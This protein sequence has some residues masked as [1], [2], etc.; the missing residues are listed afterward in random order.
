MMV[1]LVPSSTQ[2]ADT[3]LS[4]VGGTSMDNSTHAIKVTLMSQ[5]TPW[6]FCIGTPLPSVNIN[7]N[8][9]GTFGG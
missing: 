9:M 3:N 6:Y 5:S 4:A 1:T 7:N 2:Q 8:P